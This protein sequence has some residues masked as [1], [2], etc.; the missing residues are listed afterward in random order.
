MHLLWQDDRGEHQVADRQTADEE[1]RRCPHLLRAQH[2]DDDDGVTDD[3]DDEPEGDKDDEEEL[4]ERQAGH[5]TRPRG[6]V[7]A[8][9]ITTSCFYRQIIDTVSEDRSISVMLISVVENVNIG[10]RSLNS[11]GN[12]FYLASI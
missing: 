10:A 12:L 5:R 8:S 3:G 9:C 6:L 2:H 11:V 4:V 1:V 7:V